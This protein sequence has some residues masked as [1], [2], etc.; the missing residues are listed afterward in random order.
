M[1]WDQPQLRSHC[2]SVLAAIQILSDELHWRRQQKPVL[3]RSF[4]AGTEGQPRS[5][6]VDIDSTAQGHPEG[7]EGAREREQEDTSGVAEREG[8]Q[9]QGGEETKREP[10]EER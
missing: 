5:D 9:K 10:G 3:T 2:C 6:G 8:G 4:T 7:T 1:G